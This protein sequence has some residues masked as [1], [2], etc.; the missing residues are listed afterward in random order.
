MLVVVD[1][2]LLVGSVL[3][4]LRTGAGGG[5]S[6]RA[7]PRWSRRT[8]RS[9]SSRSPARY[10]PGSGVDGIAVAGIALLG[11]S[12]LQVRTAVGPRTVPGSPS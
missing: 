10:A 9:P 6:P 4:A 5:C 3:T 7:S 2:L 8:P 1:A 12:A 11:V